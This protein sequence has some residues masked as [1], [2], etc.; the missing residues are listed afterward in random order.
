MRHA[1]LWAALTLGALGCRATVLDGLDEAEAND[2]VAALRAAGFD[3]DKVSRG[4]RHAVDVDH[5]AFAEAWGAARASGFPRPIAPPPP[6]GL[7]ASAEERQAAARRATEAAVAAVLRA[8]PAVSDARVAL[9][10]RGAAVTV[11]SPT[12]AGLDR[13]TLE[14]QVRVAADLPA[15]AA[16]ALA[17]HPLARPP[18]PAPAPRPAW[19]LWLATAAVVS[20]GGACGLWWRWMRRAR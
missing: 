15:D 13:A 10:R 2:L 12:P 5:A 3:A 16:V 20:M 1:V 7:V 14:A 4:G 11:H 9:G 17:I 19:P 6:G 18:R 8:D